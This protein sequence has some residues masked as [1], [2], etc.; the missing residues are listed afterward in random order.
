MFRRLLQAPVFSKNALVNVGRMKVLHRGLYLTRPWRKEYMLADIGEGITECEIVQ[1]F[2]KPGDTIAQ[3]D[4][5]CEVQSDKAAVEITSRYDGVVKRLHYDVGEMAIVGQP[6]IE[7]DLEEEKIEDNSNGSMNSAEKLTEPNGTLD[8]SGHTSRSDVQFGSK[9]I[10]STPAVRRLAK[11]KSINLND[12]KGTGKDGRILKEDIITYLKQ[13]S[14]SQ[15]KAPVAF[16]SNISTQ[17][18]TSPLE[19]DLRPLTAVQRGMFKSM[20]RSLKIPH[21]G[22]ADEIVMDSCIAM[23]KQLQSTIGV[24]E[25]IKITYMP[26]LVKAMSLALRKF[27]ILNASLVNSGDPNEARLKYRTAHNIGIAMDTPAGLLVPNVKNVEKKSI[28]E[29]AKDLNRLQE[30][31]QRGQLS[32]EDLSG[33]TI[34][35]S[36][37]GIIG[38][39]YTSPVLVDTELCIGALGR[40]RKMVR[41]EECHQDGALVDQ[42][43]IRQVMA[44][45]WSADHRVID[46][47]TMA[48]FSEEW[49]R[50][51]EH[52][53]L[54]CGLLV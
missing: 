5:I 37:V 7:I 38:G 44:I 1:W 31:G 34:T 11:E 45:S 52:P 16:S 19:G 29:V 21:F 33:G 53:E 47:A 10:L 23:R 41:I 3:F 6:L 25:N 27:P 48:R 22:Y 39:T 15:P 32:L 8:I 49:R 4:K 13:S 26:I 24:Q 36:N 9:T 43:I 35:L 20:T 50:L 12:I 14:S 51:I 30:L 28:V 42:M 54:M 40:M 46:G 18:A 2:V 17:I